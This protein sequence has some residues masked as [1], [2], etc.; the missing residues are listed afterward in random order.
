MYNYFCNSCEQSEA[1]AGTVR[2]PT[3]PGH[4]KC[5]VYD[6]A[7]AFKKF[8]IGLPGGIIGSPTLFDLF[9]S[10]NI[11]L[12]TGPELTR[13]KLAYVRARLIALAILNLSSESRRNLIYSV[14]GLLCM[15]GRTAEAMK[16]KEDQDKSLPT[17]D[18]MGYGSLG[19]TFGPIIIGDLIEN[20]SMQISNPK[21]GLI[22]LPISQPKSRKEK[23]MRSGKIS[24][25]KDVDLQMDK[26]EMA[27]KITEMIITEWCDVVQHIKNLIS[28]NNES[29]K[30]KSS[31]S[32]A[33]QTLLKPHISENSCKN[34][35]ERIKPIPARA[36]HDKRLPSV[37]KG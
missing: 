12:N 26:I 22:L 5:D 16:S 15:I 2:S 28:R 13:K 10:I 33:A 20:Y 25:L 27:N 30:K 35:F 11:Q 37:I 29:K 24:E 7:S 4:I 8:L 9:I 23:K 31:T 1:V 21:G 3:L 34:S 14:F 17:S 6:I 18:L 19:T 36:I 32:S